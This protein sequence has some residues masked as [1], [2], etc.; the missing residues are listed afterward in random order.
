MATLPAES[1]RIHLTPDVAL[2]EKAGMIA[3]REKY[4]PAR[5]AGKPCAMGFAYVMEFTYLK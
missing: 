3:M 2:S 4:K 5:C 1:V